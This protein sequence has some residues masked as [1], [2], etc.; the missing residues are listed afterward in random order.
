MSGATKEILYI[1]TLG[2]VSVVLGVFISWVPMVLVL[3]TVVAY[4]TGY[5]F[6]CL[7]IAGLVTELF[8]WSYP[9]LFLAVFFIPWSIRK[10]FQ[11]IEIDFKPGFYLVILLGVFLQISLIIAYNV[12][13][14]WRGN[15]KGDLVFILWSYVP[16]FKTFLTLIVVF[17]VSST[18]SAFIYI[19]K[20]W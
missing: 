11:N 19:N 5:S 2:G 14:E 16:W 8:S 13:L 1:M 3:P 4:T 20:R 9:G 12:L 10:I 6:V 17:V 15:R 7:L 18:L